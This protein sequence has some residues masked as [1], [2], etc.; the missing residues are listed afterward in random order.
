MAI[1]RFPKEAAKEL[2]L[3]K[4]LQLTKELQ[5]ELQAAQAARQ[6]TEGPRKLHHRAKKVGF[7]MLPY[8]Q[9]MAAAGKMKNATLAVMVELA[10]QVF[11]NHESEVPLSNSMLRTLGISRSAKLRA[12]RQLEAAGMV[13][14]SGKGRRK[15]PRVTVLWP[16]NL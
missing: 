13:K 4:E 1:A 5:E 10:Y 8:A 9:T 7:V 12:L 3:M 16:G 2:H 15:T 14:I 6:A 11:K